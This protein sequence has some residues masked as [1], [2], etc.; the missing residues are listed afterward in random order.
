M[1]IQI[2]SNFKKQTTKAITS[3]IIFIVF[4]IVLLCLAL[5]FT[6]TCIGGG[7]AIIAAKPMFFTLALGV[8]LAGLGI[9]II[10][11]LFKFMFKKH[12]TD[13]SNYKEIS[14]QEEPKLFA[15]IDEI[16]NTTGT[17]FP[18]K[19]YLSSEVN[20]SVFYDSSFWSMF[21][22]IQKNL[23]I[24][25]GLVNSVTH[26]ELKAILSH[27]FGHFSQ[28]SMKVGSYVYNVNQIIYNLL[29]DN[30]SYGKLIDKWANLSGYF[31]IFVGI[32]IKIIQG[33]QWALSKMYAIVNKNYLALSREMEFHADEV[34]A[35]VTGYLPLKTSLLRLDLANQGFNNVLS[36]YDTK[37]EEALTSENLFKEQT[38]VMN[39]LA[40]KQN[41]SVQNNLP[42]VTKNDSNTFSKSKL[43]IKNQWASHPEIEE[44]IEAL[45]KLNIVLANPNNN[46]ANTIFNNIENW[47]KHFTNKIFSSINYSKNETK[48][49]LENFKNDY[50][51]L[52]K[53][54]TFNPIFLNYYDNYTPNNFS[55]ENPSESNYNFDMLFNDETSDWTK[56]LLVL[57]N[58]KQIVEAIKNK[59]IDCN[60]FDFEGV[61]YK[62]KEAIK[63]KNKI[64]IYIDELKKKLD[65]NDQNIFNTFY[66]IAKKQN[67]E[68]HYKDACLNYLNF[69]KTFDKNL[70]LYSKIINYLQFTLETTPYET[71]ILKF[72][73]FKHFEELFQKELLQIAQIMLYRD[74]ITKEK[75]DLIEK[76]SSKPNNY[77]SENEYNNESL[78]NLYEMLNLFQHF[79]QRNYF[80]TKKNW[81]EYQANLLK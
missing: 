69:D 34:A 6:L 13:L 41:I 54:E 33:I 59:Q 43:I 45:E 39:F 36:F 73:D 61:K 68:I 63:V 20:A 9:M 12:K 79:N 27:E 16:V 76:F 40:E 4:Y 21:L 65:A 29:Y 42:N 7:I 44:R 55:V 31:S 17:K 71:I 46:P 75:F 14:R 25:L 80:H 52:Y 10:I 28:K 66:T 70:E 51:E 60:T 22:P 53:K 11:F 1:N 35:N 24:G 26:D 37:I 15:F 50:S 19:V 64:N 56:E 2:S 81:I 5:L 23:H 47:Q 58:D 57:E 30:E 32:G 3:I 38:F 78:Q 67:K 62:R 8:G 48:N 18:K 77:F 74:E 72:K 49:S